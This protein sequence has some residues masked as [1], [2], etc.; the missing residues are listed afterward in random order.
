MGENLVS[1]NFIHL[2]TTKE[3]TRTVVSCHQ[4]ASA[5]SLIALPVPSR[6]HFRLIQSLPA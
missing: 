2:P 5:K 4:P 1:S 3:M 6:S